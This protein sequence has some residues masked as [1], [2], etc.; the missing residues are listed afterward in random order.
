M[1]V[2]T[3]N[4]KGLEELREG[5]EIIDAMRREGQYFEVIKGLTDLMEMFKEDIEFYK[6]I[7]NL[8][9]DAKDMWRDAIGAKKPPKPDHKRNYNE[10]ESD[11]DDENLRSCDCC[12]NDRD[13]D[14]N[15]HT[16]SSLFENEDDGTWNCYEC[17]EK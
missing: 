1:K 15:R 4:E 9:N 11:S 12:L 7:D 3:L 13:K 16:Y 8:R 6:L 5:M 2:A 10:C 17:L 14:G